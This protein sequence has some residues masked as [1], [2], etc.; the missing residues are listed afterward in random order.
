ME[1]DPTVYIPLEHAPRYVGV[2]V[3]TPHAR[4]M[5]TV[6]RETLA[7][8]DPNLPAVS[9]RTLEDHY[10]EDAA[11]LGYIAKT[12]AGLGTVSLVLAVSGL[13]SVIAFFVALRTNE[14][15]VRVALGAR[16]ADIVRMVVGQAGRLVLIGLGVGAVLGTPLLVGFNTLLP[17]TNPFDPVLIVPVAV[18]LVVT[19]LAAAWIP[20]RRAASIEAS[21]ALRTE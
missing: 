8:A 1:P 5:I 11:F 19:A 2:W 7:Q 21:V 20:A 14:F 13:Y 12:A 6:A 10:N 18:I 16:A 3:K 15:G 17:I 9:I 4:E